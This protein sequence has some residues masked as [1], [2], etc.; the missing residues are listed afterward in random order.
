VDNGWKRLSINILT[1]NQNT[2]PVTASLPLKGLLGRV[3]KRD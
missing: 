1:D 2:D 3:D